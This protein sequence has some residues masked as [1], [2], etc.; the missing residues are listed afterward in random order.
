VT[1][2]R[3]AVADIPV[4]IAAAGADTVPTAPEADAPTMPTTTSSSLPIVEKGAADRGL[5]PN[6][7]SPPYGVSFAAS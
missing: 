4:R 1:D 6:M 2:P 5:K 7:L 3:L